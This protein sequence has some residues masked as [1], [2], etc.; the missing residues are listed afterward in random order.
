MDGM[1]VPSKSFLHTTATVV[2]SGTGDWFQ[3]T[4]SLR[5]FSLNSLYDSNKHSFVSSCVAKNGIK[6]IKN[7]QPQH[8]PLFHL[9]VVTLSV[10]GNSITTTKHI[11]SL[12]MMDLSQ[13][14][15]TQFTS[16]PFTHFTHFTFHISHISHISHFS[17]FTHH[18]TTQTSKHTHS[19]SSSPPHSP[20]SH[21]SKW[22]WYIQNH[23][24]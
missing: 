24:M 15:S 18:T 21:S 16:F 5:W 20:G 1:M 11:T 7:H 9:L 4:Q 22:G 17:H 19:L 8:I 10:K 3:V 13:H 6:I 23:F 12:W 2:R 14:I